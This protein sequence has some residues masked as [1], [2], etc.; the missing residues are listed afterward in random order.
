MAPTYLKYAAGI[1]YRVLLLENSLQV[2]LSFWPDDQFR[3]TE[4]GFKIVFGEANAPTT[5]PVSDPERLAGMGWL[6]ALHA[7]SAIARGRPWQAVLMLD[8][9]RDQIISLLCVR[10]GLNPHQGRGVLLAEVAH[11]D[12][13]LARR[14]TIPARYLS[15]PGR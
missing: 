10:H 15:N 11:H 9:I 6:Y 7:R 1:L 5:P 4:P 2:D 13:E 8:G 14:L 3:A 12:P